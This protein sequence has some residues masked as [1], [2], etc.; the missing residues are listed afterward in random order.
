MQQR[1]LPSRA[2]KGARL[3]HLASRHQPSACHVREQRQQRRLGA[4]RLHRQ[5]Q[6]LLDNLVVEERNRQLAQAARGL[7]LV[8]A[9]DVLLPR[10]PKPQVQ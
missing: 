6:R 5:Q 9:R 10:Q 4:G 2:G 3:L 7:R 8:L 1:T